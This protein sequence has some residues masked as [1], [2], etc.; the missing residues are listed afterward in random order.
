MQD[1]LYSKPFQKVV[2][3]DCIIELNEIDNR[4]AALEKKV[5]IVDVNLKSL[6]NSLQEFNSQLVEVKKNTSQH[7]EDLASQIFSEQ[8]GKI[9]VLTNELTTKLEEV[10]DYSFK[11]NRDRS[12]FQKYHKSIIFFIIL[13]LHYFLLLYLVFIKV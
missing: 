10:M 13:L 12:F 3:E 11:R 8:L 7:F 5:E 9:E 2:L 4:I 6:N 1:N